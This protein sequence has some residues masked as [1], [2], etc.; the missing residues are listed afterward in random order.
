MQTM[1]LIMWN[2]MD[3]PA[4]IVPFSKVTDADEKAYDEIKDRELVKFVLNS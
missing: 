4:G 3:M 2:V 1:P